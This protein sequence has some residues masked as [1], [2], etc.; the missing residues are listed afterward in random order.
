[1]IYVRHTRV[2]LTLAV[3]M[4]FSGLSEAS[5]VTTKLKGNLIL[6]PDCAADPNCPV[7]TIQKG[8]FLLKQSDV[9]GN[10]GIFFQFS[11]GEVRA[12]NTSHSKSPVN[13]RNHKRGSP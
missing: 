4:I 2:I 9:A 11:M 8:T 3:G 10:F 1:M 13:S 12:Q 7:D 6:D 5:A